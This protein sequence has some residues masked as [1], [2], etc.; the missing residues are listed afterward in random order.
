MPPT[1]GLLVIASGAALWGF[2]MVTP[3]PQGTPWWVG[4]VMSGVGVV[5]VARGLLG[6]AGAL[7]DLFRRLRKPPGWP[8][9]RAPRTAEETAQVLARRP[10]GWE[11]LYFA[12][13]LVTERA[14]LEHSFLDH[15]LRYAIPSGER[16]DDDDAVDYLKQAI[17]DVLGRIASLVTLMEADVQERAFGPLGQPGDPDRIRHLA[18]RWTSVYEDLMNWAAR[19]RAATKSSTFR[20]LFEALA[21]LIERP[22]QQYRDFVDA[23]VQETDGIPRALK[24][25]ERLEINLVLTLSI[26]DDAL[27]AISAEIARLEGMLHGVDDEPPDILTGEDPQR[28]SDREAIQRHARKVSGTYQAMAHLQ[29]IADTTGDVR[30]GMQQRVTD[31]QGRL[32][33]HRA[34]WGTTPSDVATFVHED[35]SEGPTWLRKMVRDLDLIA[36]QLEHEG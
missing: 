2:A 25:G 1:A 22:I 16:V 36:W 27:A 34:K 31:L 17:D 33:A 11:Y 29:G 18:R 3:A 26:D 13:S 4:W 7:G 15:E 14:T 12:G 28:R 10:P 21:R 19:L 24:T 32:A 35:A 9:N 6:I 5:L 20:D 8:G 23:F 30:L